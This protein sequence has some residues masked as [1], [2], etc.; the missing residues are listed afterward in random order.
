MSTED[1]ELTSTFEGNDPTTATAPQV[2]STN[3]INFSVQIHDSNVPTPHSPISPRSPTWR[4][5]RIRTAQTVDSASF[6]LGPGV[7][8]WSLMR[9][10]AFVQFAANVVIFAFS[11]NSL[12]Q[13]GLGPCDSNLWTYTIVSSAFR[14]FQIVLN[15]ALCFV[16]P[17]RIRRYNF[18]A[19][20]RVQISKTLWLATVLVLTVQVIMIPIGYAFL[21]NANPACQNWPPGTNEEAELTVVTY[22]ALLIQMCA[23]V[24][25]SLPMFCLPCGLA[26]ADLPTYSG[27][28]SIQMSQIPTITIPAPNS[29]PLAANGGS[30]ILG[31]PDGSS[32]SVCLEELPQG[33][34]AKQLTCGHV[35]HEDCLSQWFEEHRSCPYCRGN[36]IV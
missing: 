15:F 31:G 11:V 1:V 8:A 4:S 5:S 12:T 7:I 16:L 18:Q 33:T 23:F 34:R 9:A 24:L 6:D 28:T 25:I 19:F 13:D 35:A 3:S 22:F 32:C 21:Y 26:L 2:N 10:W 30:T 29:N 20:R 14:G 17:H 27:I 36:A